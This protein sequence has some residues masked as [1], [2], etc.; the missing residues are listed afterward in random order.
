MVAVGDRMRRCPTLVI[1]SVAAVAAALLAPSN[2]RAASCDSKVMIVLDRSCSMDNKPSGQTQTKWQSAEAAIEMLTTTY[3]D[4]LR[5]GLIMFPDEAGDRCTQDG[6]I[7]VTTG[8]DRGQ[9][10]RDAIAGTVPNGPCVTNIDTAIEQVSVDPA[11]DGTPDPDGRRGFVLLITD[12][13][14]SKSCGGNTNDA[15]TI[16]NIETLYQAGYPTYVVGFGG[17]VDPDDLDA[18]ATAGGVPRAA[19]PL[20]YQADDAVALAEALDAIAG[21]ITGDPEFGCPGVPCPDQRCFGD[22]ETCVDGVCLTSL[23]DAGP[24]PDASPGGGDAGDRDGD[25]GVG[26]SADGDAGGCGCRSDTGAGGLGG[27]LLAAAAALVVR[28]RRG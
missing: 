4:Q 8:A 21:D 26:G 14:Q 23:P 27:L 16:A 7:Y 3:A 5:F 10:V 6:N 11:F 25:G 15:F 20:Y 28:R 13:K 24:Q 9:A 22:Y 12:G 1:G 17:G 19:S 18:F 2:A